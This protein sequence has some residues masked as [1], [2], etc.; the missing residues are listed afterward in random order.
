M[1][2]LLNFFTSVRVA[3]TLLI[4]LICASIVGTLVPQGGTA[5][6]YAVRYGQFGSVLE[7]LQLTRLYHSF[8]YIALLALFALNIIVCTLERLWPKFRHASTGRLFRMRMRCRSSST[9]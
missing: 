3:I 1:R 7:R 2:A 8:W 6:D 9:L 5:Q 4:I